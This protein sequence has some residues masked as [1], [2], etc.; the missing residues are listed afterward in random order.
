[1]VTFPG[2]IVSSLTNYF[3][4]DFNTQREHWEKALLT[5]LKIQEV[6]NK[7]SKKMPNGMS[8][9]TLS[10]E[11]KG[12]V[13]LSPEVAWKKAANTYV[14]QGNDTC[15][16]IA[17]DLKSGVRNF[18]FHGEFL[19]K[20]SWGLI[21]KELNQVNNPSELEVF[22][23]GNYPQFKSDSF[24]VITNLITGEKAHNE[25]GHS[26]QE[27]AYL[28]KN[29]IQHNQDKET[30]IGVYVDSFF[31]HNIAKLRAARLLAMKILQE[32]G[33]DSA[34]KVVALT[35]YQGWT[36]F[37]RYSNMLR[38]E[39]AVA[40]AYVGGADHVQ[41][42][43]Y[44]TLFELEASDL[45]EDEHTDRSARMAR[46]TS[47]ILGLE[48]MLGV[49]QDAA[50]GSYHLENLTHTLC[51][52]SWGL[53]QRLL[54]NEDFSG[55]ITAVRDQRLQNLKTRKTVMSGINDFPD[56]KEKLGLK[57][58][59]S[60]FFRTARIFEELRLRIEASHKPQVY[61]ALFGDYGSLNARL[62]FVKNYFELLGLTVHESGH[63][64]FDK[65]NFE[66]NL[67]AR[68]EEIVVLCAPDDQYS[69][70]AEAASRVKTSYKF[71]AGKTEMNSWK[72]LFAGQNVYEVLLDIV[73]AFE[74]RK[75]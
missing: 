42:S 37:E 51:E 55:E 59:S 31:F 22:I 33:S 36:L 9:P 32:N 45:N 64:E 11:R 23:L 52:E 72:N 38:N 50:F 44:Q 69:V 68:N 60:R 67:L 4:T 70:I 12:E 43:G 41:S 71:I 53:M 34:L 10:I 15:K 65:E 28:A 35:S 27:L 24:K 16:L 14:K 49:V 66:K 8:W 30:F 73:A 62:N 57:L 40:S 47:H 6:G 21:E 46:N 20:R 13:Q 63:S 54:K 26:V 25:G 75:S 3:E 17:E 7:A 1:M 58:T 61:I 18:F 29:L 39:T 19:D 5:E 2:V 74:G 56:V 48:S